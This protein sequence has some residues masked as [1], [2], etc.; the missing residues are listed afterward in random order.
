MR[1]QFQSPSAAPE[2]PFELWNLHSALPRKVRALFDDAHYAEATFTACKY[3]EQEVKLLSKS[4]RIGEALMLATFNED[5]PSLLVAPTDK[6][7]Q[8]GYKFLFAGVVA[9]IR[10]P[11]GHQAVVPDDLNTCLE[12]LS[13][14]SHLLRKLE[15]AGHP[16]R[17]A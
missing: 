15:K 14:V 8:R 16:L 7:E 17:G 5:G 11:R 12:H 1:P 10:N 2:H 6:D 13:L 9:G 4:S 3:L